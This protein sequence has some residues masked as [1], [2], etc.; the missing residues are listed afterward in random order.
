MKDKTL[1]I[2][3]K[4][5]GNFCHLNVGKKVSNNTKNAEALWGGTDRFDH[6]K[7]STVYPGSQEQVKAYPTVQ[8]EK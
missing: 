3:V 2:I 5:I 4:R 1:K 8:S 6:I 7:I